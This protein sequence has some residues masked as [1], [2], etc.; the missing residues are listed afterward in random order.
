MKPSVYNVVFTTLEFWGERI[1][2]KVKMC[3]SY[4]DRMASIFQEWGKQGYFRVLQIPMYYSYYK[5]RLCF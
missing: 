3:M 1:P 4:V 2:I 5:W